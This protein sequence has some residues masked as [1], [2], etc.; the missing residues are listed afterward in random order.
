MIKESSI[1][2]DVILFYNENNL[3]EKRI[4]YFEDFKNIIHIVVEIDHSYNGK[5]RIS[6]I[7]KVLKSKVIH[8]FIEINEKDVNLSNPWD[9]EAFHR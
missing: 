3:L 2:Y 5:K 7:N 9:I 4:K 8:K 6:A 1:I